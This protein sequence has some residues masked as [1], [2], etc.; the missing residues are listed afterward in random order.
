MNQKNYIPQLTFPRFLAAALVVIYHYGSDTYPFNT[1]YIKE[2]V[3]QGSV[4]VSFFFFLSGL[5]LSLNYFKDETLRFSTFLKKRI[6]RIYPVYI[7]AFVLSLLLAMWLRN[8]FPKGLSVIL[9][10][11]ALHAWVPG[12]C[13]EINYP[14]W[15]ISVEMF[16]YLVFP[17]FIFL[18]RKMSILRLSLV[19]VI[20]WTISVFQ[21]LYFETHFYNPDKIAFGELIL[22]FPLWHL[23][24]FLFGMLGGIVIR[25]KKN[26]DNFSIWPGLIF[27]CGFL[28]FILILGTPNS[29]RP[30]IHNGLLSPLYFMMCYGL[31]MDRT[32]ISAFSGRKELVYLGDISYGIYI[33]QFPVYLLF[34]KLVSIEKTQGIYFYVYFLVLIMVSAASYSFA[35]QKIRKMIIQK[36][37]VRDKK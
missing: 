30:H 35:E 17:F 25:N 36:W 1:G 20:I 23:N 11:A 2:I 32:I 9:Q 15:S 26:N 10:F 6:A 7:F 34:T 29:I 3:S 18:F 27:L 21:N 19:V 4:A 28:I 8:A 24:T 5:V 12:I 22:Y 37:I 33:L 14:G 13:L 31:A 16:F